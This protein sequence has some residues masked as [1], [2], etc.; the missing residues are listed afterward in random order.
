MRCEL[1]SDQYPSQFSLSG[2][3]F[4]PHEAPSSQRTRYRSFVNLPTKLYG[5]NIVEY[6]SKRENQTKKKTQFSHPIFWIHHRHKHLNRDNAQCLMFRKKWKR[7]FR[8][9][10]TAETHRKPAPPLDQPPRQTCCTN[11]TLEE[12]SATLWVITYSSY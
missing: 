2:G 1:Q 5:Q 6:K 3:I 4:H 11:T 7:L 10:S 12:T 9:I 8:S